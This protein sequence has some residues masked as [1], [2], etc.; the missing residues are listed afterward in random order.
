[1]YRAVSSYVPTHLFFIPNLSLY[2]PLYSFEFG[3][4]GLTRAHRRDRFTEFHGL[5]GIGHETSSDGVFAFSLASI[6]ELYRVT[7]RDPSVVSLGGKGKLTAV[8]RSSTFPLVVDAPL[9][10][11][12]VFEACFAALPRRVLPV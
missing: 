8:Y 9:L 6:F 11:A 10:N 12:P 3:A 5:A 1:M 2:C 4:H 7:V